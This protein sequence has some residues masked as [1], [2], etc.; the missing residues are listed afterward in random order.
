ELAFNNANDA[1]LLY[2]LDDQ[3]NPGP[4]I[5]VNDAAVR[6]YCYSREELLTLTSRDLLGPEVDYKP[7]AAALSSSDKL[8]RNSTHLTRDGRRIPVEVSA[9]RFMMDG[10]QTVLLVNRDLSERKRAA[11]ALKESEERYRTLFNSIDVGFC[12]VEV[13]FDADDRAHD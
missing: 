7:A 1:M 4:C 12:V 13:L 6:L 2:H 5:E 9:H 3:G 11:T 8:L 10:R